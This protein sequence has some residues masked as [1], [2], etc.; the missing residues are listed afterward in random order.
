MS[1]SKTREIQTILA[2]VDE[3]L[4]KRLKAAGIDIGHVLLAITS[5]GAGIVRSNIAPAELGEMAELLTDIASGTDLQRP[6]D[7]P[8][9]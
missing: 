2:E 4:C 5:D 9:N 8:L 6:D 1:D 3:L 7:E